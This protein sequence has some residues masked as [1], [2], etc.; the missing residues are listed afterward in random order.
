MQLL[1]LAA[2]VRLSGQVWLCHVG[3]GAIGSAGFSHFAAGAGLP[4][5]VA[6]ALAG[7]VA[8][9]VGALIAIPAIRLSGVYLAI[10]TFG[11]GILL[12]RL[13]YSTSFMFGTSTNG[14]PAPRPRA[15]GLDSDTGYYFVLLFFAVAMALLVI[16][17]SRARLGRLLRA[18]ADSP[19]A[20]A[21]L[22]TKVNV[23]RVL[24]FCLSA[25]LAGVAGALSGPVVGR[26]SGSSYDALTSLLLLVVL[27]ISGRGL[28][29]A[30]ALAA[31]FL[32]LPDYVDALSFLDGYQGLLFGLAA[33][34]A[35]VLERRGSRP[36]ETAPTGRERRVRRRT[37]DR[38][39]PAAARG[40]MRVGV[41]T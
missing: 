4:W 36:G 15:L 21:T 1:A 12:Q 41:S 18:L 14:V 16:A 26:S 28:I 32:V 9:P 13:L 23:I 39:G 2:L 30:P 20:L 31:V 33:M 24:A 38:R 35:G 25:F 10:A 11:F 19:T 7:L 40:S 29:A 8:V 22:G 37:G 6:V 5:L 3:F 17:V 27:L 34:T